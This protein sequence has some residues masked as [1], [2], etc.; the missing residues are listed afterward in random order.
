MVSLTHMARLLEALRPQARLILVGDADQ[1]VSV[2]AGAVLGDLVAGAEVAADPPVA[3]ARL[4]TVH[5]FG[6]TIGALAEALRVGDADSV[7]AALSAGSD[8]VRWV[9]DEDPVTTLRPLLTQQA[10][11]VLTAA[12]DGDAEGVE[13]EEKWVE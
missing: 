8:E 2:D 10:Y 5:R 13:L 3:L 9:R 7:V 6:E 11:R 1:L 4:R 12:R